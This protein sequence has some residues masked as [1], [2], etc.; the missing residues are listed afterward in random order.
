[1]DEPCF[2]RSG[3]QALDCRW[4]HLHRQTS[5]GRF[6]TTVPFLPIDFRTGETVV[7]KL[8]GGAYALDTFQLAGVIGP[9]GVLDQPTIS[10]IIQV[11]PGNWQVA[12]CLPQSFR[13][14]ELLVGQGRT[15]P[16]QSR[17]D[18][19]RPHGRSGS[20]TLHWL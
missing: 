8:I 6:H 4:G 10:G 17:A 12:Q 19:G 2:F 16:P 15:L 13:F 9:N 5:T 20:A 3:A 14:F 18:L 7:E 11:R 1:M